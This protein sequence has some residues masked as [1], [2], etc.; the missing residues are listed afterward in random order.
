MTPVLPLP[1]P[2]VIENP[3]AL[4]AEKPVSKENSQEKPIIDA[5]NVAAFFRKFKDGEDRIGIVNEL[6]KRG[7]LAYLVEEGTMI[8]GYVSQK[9]L[10]YLVGLRGVSLG[11]SGPDQA[12]LFKLGD[13]PGEK[14][15][16]RTLIGSLPTAGAARGRSLGEGAYR[17]IE[18][19]NGKN[20]RV[21]H[22]DLEKIPL[23]KVKLGEFDLQIPTEAFGLIETNQI[24]NVHLNKAYILKIDGNSFVERIKRAQGI[25]GQVGLIRRYDKFFKEVTEMIKTEVPEGSV[26]FGDAQTDSE[27]LYLPN[28]FTMRKIQEILERAIEKH[29]LSIKISGTRKDNVNL[30]LVDGRVAI[31]DK[32]VDETD[33]ATNEEV[34]KKE[35]QKHSDDENRAFIQ[36]QIRF[37]D[38]NRRRKILHGEIRPPKRRVA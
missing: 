38:S 27:L 7:V 1:R 15:G 34:I 18:K 33:W 24:E 5:G 23:D 28:I 6:R 31:S 11:P 4:K 10:D 14:Q 3:A 36:S 37:R 25:E 32:P 17:V 9:G 16:E 35:L 8:G 22:T 26:F 2:E 19:G 21:K 13:K 20:I 29:H 30:T 12:A